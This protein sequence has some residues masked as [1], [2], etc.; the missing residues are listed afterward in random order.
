MK[1]LFNKLLAVLI[2]VLFIVPAFAA[3]SFA[4]AEDSVFFIGPEDNA[5]LTF[6]VGSYEKSSRESYMF[7][8]NTV[9][10]SSVTVRYNGSFASVTGNAVTE[11]NAEEKTITVDTTVATAITA[12]TRRLIFMQSA[13]PSMSIVLNEGESMD[14]INA[15]KEARIGATVSIDGTEGGT[16]DLAP[17]AIEMKTRGNTTFWPDKKPYQIKFDKKQDLFGMGKAKKWILL[18]NYYDGT[19]V[20]TKVFFDLADEIGLEY[21]G[22]STF[23]DLY[24]DGDYRGVYQITEKIEIGSTR[25]DLKDEYG[26]VLEMED[27]TRTDV[28]NDIF[29]TTNEADKDIL[30]KDYVFDFEDVSTP[31]RLAK[32]NEIMDFVEG[33]INGLEAEMYSADPDWDVISSMIDVDSFALYYL[34]NEYGEQVDCMLASTY[35]YIDGPGDVLHCG[36][37]WDFDRVCGFNDPIAKNTDFVKNMNDYTDGRRAEWYKELFRNPEFVKR[38]NEL[39]EERAKAAFDTAKVN[40]AIDA[41]QAELMPSLLMNHVKWVVFYDRSYTADELVSTG[42]VDRIAYTTDHVKSVLSD[43]KAYMDKAYSADLPTVSVVTYNDRGREQKNY[44]GGC[45][46][47]SSPMN[48]LKIELID[49]PF[50]GQISYKMN[51]NGT[52]TDLSYGGEV[53]KSSAGFARANGIY[54]YLEGNITNYVDI[55]YRVNVGGRWGAWT[56]NGRFSGRS[57]SNNGQ[58][59]VDRVQVRLLK[60]ADAVYADVNYVAEGLETVTDRQIV[61]N[62]YRCDY[63]PEKDGYAFTGWY[64]DAD[65]TIPADE[66]FTVENISYTFYAGFERTVRKGDVDGNGRVNLRDLMAL[67]NCLID[68]DDGMIFENTDMNSDGIINIKDLIVLRNLLSGIIDEEDLD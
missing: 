41:L 20:R 23:V 30:Y 19:S 2:V 46:T 11:W 15:D 68:F 50:D 65:C 52:L 62:A 38:V 40:A 33:R 58:Y 48:G 13:L 56:T 31:E 49:S 47:Y 44:T 24:I 54:I 37:V 34:L 28:A 55:Q 53:N 10:P 12:G 67:K 63:V 17:L 59:Y 5:G 42:T 60:K 14:T 43:K 32:R 35:Y 21:S 25:V 16:Y 7:L 45:M 61:G 64:T 39:Y 27:N 26:V 29:F 1:N 36:P 6:S 3:G 66:D 4:A 51:V 18:A 57:S 22:K 8:P 9:D